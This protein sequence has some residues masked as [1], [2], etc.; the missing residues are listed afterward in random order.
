M[1]N[2]FTQSKGIQI[3]KI[4]IIFGTHGSAQTPH[5]NPEGPQEDEP[6][7]PVAEIPEELNAD[8]NLSTHFSPHLGQIIFS[9]PKLAENTNSSN[10]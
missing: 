9:E 1:N 3:K 10:I 6:P 7:E 2:K 8:I 4:K 5:E